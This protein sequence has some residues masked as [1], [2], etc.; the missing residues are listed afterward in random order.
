MA[1]RRSLGQALELTPEQLEFVRGKVDAPAAKNECVEERDDVNAKPKST[2]HSKPRTRSRKSQLK[3]PPSLPDVERAH[4][5]ADHCGLL[6]PITT[7]LRP[8]TANALR[9]ACLEQKLK[10]QNP[11]TQQEIVE[12]A[13][14]AWL[15]RTGYL[16]K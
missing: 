7:R 6:V 16:S 14:R 13:V 4:D 10:R 9:R 1:D 3:S 12:T 5:S 8:D 15:A 11:N 2:R